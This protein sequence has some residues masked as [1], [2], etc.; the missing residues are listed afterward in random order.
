MAIDHLVPRAI[1]GGSTNKN[2]QAAYN[3]LRW[4]D[5]RPKPT[6]PDVLAAF[7]VI[8]DSLLP[9]N[10]ERKRI[11]DEFDAKS[12]F[13]ILFKTIAVATNKTPN[14]IRTIARQATDDIITP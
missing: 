11:K 13:K 1:Y 2:T 8:E 7:A 5:P 6:W 4:N 9:H 10:Q 12:M 14:Q 3:T